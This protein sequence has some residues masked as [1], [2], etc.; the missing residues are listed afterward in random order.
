MGKTGAADIPSWRG[1]CGQIAGWLECKTSLKSWRSASAAPA[2]W[3]TASKPPGIA[4]AV[5]THRTDAPRSSSSHPPADA[6]WTEPPPSL[7]TSS[8][9]GS[10]PQSPNNN[11]TSSSASCDSFEP[12]R[13]RHAPTHEYCRPRLRIHPSQQTTSRAGFS[14]AALVVASKSTTAR[15][16]RWYR[17]R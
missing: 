12:P 9:S 16:Q 6:Y 17:K 13:V 2:S 5:P 11:L 1:R 4:D 3:L 10:T 7:R 8:P 15:L 14:A